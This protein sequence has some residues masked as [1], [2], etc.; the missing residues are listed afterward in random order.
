MT[1]T[2]FIAD[3]KKYSKKS[4]VELQLGSVMDTI[5]M[6]KNCLGA[7]AVVGI[8][9]SAIKANFALEYSITTEGFAASLPEPIVYNVNIDTVDNNGNE[10]EESIIISNQLTEFGDKRDLSKVAIYLSTLCTQ[11]TDNA[12]DPVLY[13]INCN[14]VTAPAYC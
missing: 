5:T 7:K 10:I 12:K 8:A 6:N 9:A 1:T 13:Y 2:R 3:N 11:A 4:K 14:N